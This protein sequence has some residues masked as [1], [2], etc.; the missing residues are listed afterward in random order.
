MFVA[1]VILALQAEQPVVEQ[2]E[3]PLL[4]YLLRHQAEDGSWGQRP[5]ACRC[6]DAAAAPVP[7]VDPRPFLELLGDDDPANREAGERG[8][9]AIGTLAIG[10]LNEGRLHSD[11]E[12]RGRC[13]GLLRTIKVRCPGAGDV[14]TTALALLDLL[15]AGYSHLSRDVHGGA[16]VGDR[17]KSGL[18]WL[19]A[20]QTPEGLFDPKDAAANAVAALALS[21]AYGLTGSLLLKDAAQRGA[22]AVTAAAGKDARSLAWA[23]LV[24]VSERDSLLLDDHH[25]KAEALTAALEAH[26]TSLLA[27]AAREYLR[28][29][30]GKREHP[31]AAALTSAEPAETDPET[32]MFAAAA[33]YA[34]DGPSGDPWKAWREGLKESVLPDLRMKGGLCERGS[35][36]GEGFRGRL[37]ATALNQLSLQ[38]YYRYSNVFAGPRR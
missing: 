20:R 32:R 5:A 10:A 1:A 12:V 23:A 6:P 27:L 30:F 38:T 34:L 9:R 4:R 16:C 35:W 29:S 11:A 22:N 18:R 21:E 25:A 37:R 14:E 26:P 19:M 28:K 36:E 17:V 13:A 31:I 8:L 15:G 33:I 24:V 2:P 7:S 3:L